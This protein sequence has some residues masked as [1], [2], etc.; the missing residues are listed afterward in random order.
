M[1]TFREACNFPSAIISQI[2]DTPLKSACHAV[3]ISLTVIH[4]FGREMPSRKKEKSKNIMSEGL[5]NQ[6]SKITGH[7]IKGLENKKRK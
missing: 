2:K 6:A 5:Q 7:K 4:N 1:P 3:L